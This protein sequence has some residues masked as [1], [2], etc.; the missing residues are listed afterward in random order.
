MIFRRR[1]KAP[2]SIF[3]IGFN[4]CG[5]SSLAYL[6]EKCG[7]KAAHW[8]KGKIAVGMELARINDEPLLSYTDDYDL[9]T[10]LEK[11]NLWR[12]PKLKWRYSIFR[13]YLR[14]IDEDVEQ[15]PPIY[16]FKY[17]KKLDKQYTGSKFILNTRNVDNWIESRLK[18]N[19]NNNK[20]AY[21]SCTC[22]DNVHESKEE[23]A[24][25]WRGEWEEHHASVKSYFS[26]RPNSLLVFNIEKDP[27][28]KITSFFKRLELDTSF[29]KKRN[30]TTEY[31]NLLD[32]QT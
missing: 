7:Y 15:K 13:K 18:L 31:K 5:T 26:D 24:N 17:F 3:Q 23:L 30:P 22:G 19:T 11:V 20:I 16:A 28:N 6:F 27:V 1:K 4:R 2:Y 25:C 14:E 29:W 32:N 9:Y 10:D 12:L 21:R 8:E